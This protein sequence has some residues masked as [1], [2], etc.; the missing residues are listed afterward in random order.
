M[1]HTALWVN[2]D[3]SQ[4][5]KVIPGDYHPQRGEL[6]LKCICVGVNPADWKYVLRL[7]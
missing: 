6:L 3:A 4:E 7:V 5:V 1:P 2:H